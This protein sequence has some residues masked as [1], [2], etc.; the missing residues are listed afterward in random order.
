M[1]DQE[2]AALLAELVGVY[3]VSGHEEAVREAVA[4]RLPDWARPRVDDRGNLIV[5]FGEGEEHVAFVAHLDEVGLVVKSVLDD[6]RLELSRRGGFSP[7]L[8]EA[9]SALIHTSKGAVAG[10]FEPRSDWFVAESRRPAEAL[11]AFLGTT[12]R[13][14]TLD[15][16]VT[17]GD[18]V[19]MPKKLERLGAHRAVARGFDDRVGSTAQ[20]LALARIDPSTVDRRITFAWVVEEEVGLFGAVAMGRDM[21]DIDRVHAVD[22]FVSSDDPYPPPGFARTPLGSGVVLRA[23]DNS[24]LADRSTIDYVQSLAAQHDIPT[25]IGFTGG[26]NDGSAFI[27]NGATNLPL[28]WPGRSSHS[29]AE[30]MDLR[31]LESLVDL[32]VALVED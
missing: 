15:R 17:V 9:Q 13:Q 3:G 14:E 16:G 30:I 21:P 20:L 1:G 22:T 29:P 26:G 12:S 19:T 23:M 2:P 8:W 11:T 32:I 31:D 25:Q 10:V 4:A 5:Q 6:G 28:S 7:S 18:S 24:F 27:G